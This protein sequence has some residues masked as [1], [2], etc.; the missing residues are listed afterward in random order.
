MEVRPNK[1]QGGTK[2]ATP[3]LGCIFF[4]MGVD[5]LGVR[6]RNQRV[7]HD[8]K[9]VVL[10]FSYFKGLFFYMKTV[11]GNPMAPG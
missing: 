7:Q 8:A 6:K 9:R 10:D 1:V 2:S 3:V 5:Q 11:L 4:I